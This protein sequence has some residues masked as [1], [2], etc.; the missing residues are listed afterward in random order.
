[1]R[2]SERKRLEEAAFP[3][4]QR[5]I[6]HEPLGFIDYNCLQAHAWCVVSDSGTLPE[7]S[8]FYA[9]AGHAFPAVCIRTSTER[10]EAME[11]G[12]FVL[13]GISEKGLLQSVSMAVA[14]RDAGEP[15]AAVPDYTDTCVSAKVVRIIQSYVQ[16]V[17]RF[18]W[19][20]GGI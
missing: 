6:A 11:R 20:K 13:S 4:D 18:V 17:D 12:A 10:P 7:E 19:R 9:S 3:L 15:Q 14:M 1:M 8:A 16:A 5:V 2:S